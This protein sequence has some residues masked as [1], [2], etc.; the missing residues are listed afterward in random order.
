MVAV[1]LRGFVRQSAPDI[2][3]QYVDQQRSRASSPPERT[4]FRAVSMMPRP[5]STMAGAVG[6]QPVAQAGEPIAQQFEFAGC[7]LR[8]FRDS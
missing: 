1:V 7:R 4:R 5:R 3:K 2:I 6:L 8:L